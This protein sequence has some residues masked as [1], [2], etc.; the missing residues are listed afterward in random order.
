MTNYA[1]GST[2]VLSAQFRE[3]APDGPLTNV[4]NLTITI[5]PLLGG[6]AV[7]ATTSVGITNPATGV[8]GYPWFVPFNVA[9]GQYV[10]IWEGDDVGTGDPVTATEQIGVTLPNATGGGVDSPCGW[11]IDTSCVTNWDDLPEAAQTVGYHLST[12]MLWALTGRRFGQCEIVVQ[13][14]MERRRWP[15]YETFPVPSYGGGGAGGYGGFFPYILDGSW[16]NGGCGG[17]CRCRA[18]CE[19]ALDGPTNTASIVEVT[20]NGVVVDPA[21]YQIQNGYLLVRT[22]GQCWPGCIDYSKQDPAAFTVTYLRGEELPAGLQ[23]AAG[24]LAGE[25][26]M[27]CAGDDNCRLPARLTSLTRQG[28][29]VQ[30]A[31]INSYLDLGMTEIPEVDAIV[32]ALNPYRQTERSR[33]YSLDRPRPR[34]VT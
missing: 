26:A 31:T 11:D 2:A 27:S 32:V 28:V 6:A 12:L 21:A 9:P 1:Q 23:I 15:L 22:D 10:V 25:F 17:G 3:F 7:L 13:P 30:V 29:S 16:F 4:N 24:I 5:V 18:R 34:M 14:C 33:V 20:V 8:Y 19:V